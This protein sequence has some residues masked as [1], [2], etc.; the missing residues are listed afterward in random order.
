MPVTVS[1][2]EQFSAT[3]EDD[4]VINGVHVWRAEW[5][6][7]GEQAT[8]THYGSLQVAPVYEAEQNGNCA[9]FAA[10]EVS[11]GAYVFAIPRT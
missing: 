1:L 4:V 3:E 2:A 10:T 8:V 5:Q 11:N 6:S 7:T 9:R